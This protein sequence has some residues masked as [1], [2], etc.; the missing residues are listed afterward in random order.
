MPVQARSLHSACG[1]FQDLGF[2]IYA[3]EGTAKF[4]E[5]AGVK[6]EVVNKI[7][8][9]RPNVLD[10]ILNKQV[11]LIINTPWA[12]RDAVADESAIRKAAIKSMQGEC[13]T[14][15]LAFLY[16]RTAVRTP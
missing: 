12:R 11:N 10:V 1:A 16:D 15:M 8:E 14:K 9:G 6:C 7:A 4:Y 2:K 5:Q 13:R 3:T